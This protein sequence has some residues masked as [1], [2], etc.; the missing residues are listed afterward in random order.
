MVRQERIL[1]RNGLRLSWSKPSSS[2]TLPDAV[3][4]R[5]HDVPLLF[6]GRQLEPPRSPDVRQ[7][8]GGRVRSELWVWL[9]ICL[10]HDTSSTLYHSLVIRV[11]FVYGSDPNQDDG[12]PP[13]PAAARAPRTRR[14]KGVR[15]HAR[16]WRPSP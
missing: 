10:A 4:H 11:L 15:D 2:C 14:S 16:A 12:G 7:E 3:R 1:S 13:T 5:Y 8:A 9:R 6:P